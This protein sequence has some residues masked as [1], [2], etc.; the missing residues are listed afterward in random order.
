MRTDKDIIK[1][2]TQE[3]ER[4]NKRINMLENSIQQ[5]KQENSAILDNYKKEIEEVKEI[6]KRYK[7]LIKE[8]HKTQKEYSNKMSILIS[9][10]GGTDMNG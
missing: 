3:N 8:A 2:L 5:L 6:K 9:Q 7:E 4:L 10:I 1:Q